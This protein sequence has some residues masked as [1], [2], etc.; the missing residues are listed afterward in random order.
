MKKEGCSISFVTVCMNED[1]QLQQTLLNNINDSERYGF[2]QFVIVDCS[3]GDY[4]QTWI[5][6]NVTQFI[7]KGI[8]VYY[9]LCSVEQYNPVQ[10]KNLAMT[11][12]TGS[13]VCHLRSSECI[14][15]AFIEYINEV[16]H[17][18]P[19]I[20]LTSPPVQFHEHSEEH[21]SGYLVG[22]LC[23]RKEH[24]MQ[25]G[26]FDELMIKLGNDEVDLINR[27]ELLGLERRNIFDNSFGGGIKQ[28][29]GK[30]FSLYQ[31][32]NNISIVYIM[33]HKP[34]MTELLYLYNDAAYERWNLYNKRIE[35][36]DQYNNWITNKH[37]RYKYDM[38]IKSR[39]KWCDKLSENRIEFWCN[40]ELQFSLIAQNRNRYDVMTDDSTHGLFYSVEDPWL[41]EK[42][43]LF[44]CVFYNSNVMKDNIENSRVEVNKGRNWE[45]VLIRN[46]TH[47]YIFSI[48]KPI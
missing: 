4:L 39:G 17:D 21:P 42:L 14:N 27:L 10:A 6:D 43:L 48:S 23:L 30:G 46:F 7:E 26:G 33:H 15:G 37:H 13:I 2:L 28:Q 12:A 41:L 29:V 35:G 36:C 20:F 5:K 16:F 22:R 25:V 19:N 3:Q 18:M 38:E 11:L 1:L 47:R 9:R 8:V 31:S 24:F 34:E 44:N 40:N 32:L 45:A